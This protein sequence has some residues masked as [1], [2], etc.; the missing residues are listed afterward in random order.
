MRKIDKVIV[1]T[2][3]KRLRNP[4]D[5]L[6]L[7]LEAGRKGKWT[8]EHVNILNKRVISADACEN[9]NQPPIY[10]SGTNKEATSYNKSVLARVK[11]NPENKVMYWY[12][13]EAQSPQNLD[14]W[15]AIEFLLETKGRDSN[16]DVP[17]ITFMYIGQRVLCT[18]NMAPNIGL[19]NK[20]SGKVL[21]MAF[22]EGTKIDTEPDSSGAYFCSE[23]P[24]FV[25]VL[26][27]NEIPGSFENYPDNVRPGP[28]TRQSGHNTYHHK[29]SVT[30]DNMMHSSAPYSFLGIPLLPAYGLTV[31]SVQGK[32][33][34]DPILVEPNP[35]EKFPLISSVAIYMALSRVDDIK[36]LFITAPFT[37]QDLLKWKPEDWMEMAMNNLDAK[38]L[39]TVER[40]FGQEKEDGTID[41]FT[42]IIEAYQ[43][44]PKP[45]TENKQDESQER[46]KHSN[47]QASDNIRAPAA[48]IATEELA[49]E[50]LAT[51]NKNF[52]KT[53]TPQITSTLNTLNAQNI[54]LASP[55]IG[56]SC[57]IS[58]AMC[59][60][61]LTLPKTKIYTLKIYL[62]SMQH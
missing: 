22:A 24:E 49:T 10:I 59:T 18:R 54:S 51:D 14:K 8:E 23:P 44:G 47:T 36:N 62:F 57:Y 33:Y 17:P 4:N 52:D 15:K 55:N 40:Y 35:R 19:A 61:Y 12:N 28:R 53:A 46:E 16:I 29:D 39:K 34:T 25:D 38:D 2:E 41:R 27:D 6:R 13:T 56:N 7:L 11:A 30:G 3:Q 21:R 50:Q 5:P 32:T 26:F 9:M 37:L 31:H 42:R 1:L 20:N 48:Q 43:L 60:R 45:T 58:T